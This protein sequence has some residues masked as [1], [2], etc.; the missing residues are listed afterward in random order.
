MSKHPSTRQ[1][2]VGVDY[3][4]IHFLDIRINRS[5]VEQRA[6]TIR[7]RRSVKKDNQGNYYYTQLF[8]R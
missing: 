1:R 5:A 7:K 8:Y 4:D 6:S 3:S 2:N